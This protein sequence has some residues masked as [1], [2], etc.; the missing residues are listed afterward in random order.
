M[1]HMPYGVS[2]Q[3]GFKSISEITGQTPQT[4]SP[5]VAWLNLLH[6]AMDVRSL[7]LEFDFESGLGFGGDDLLVEQ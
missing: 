2:F 4:G 7:F 5:W 3:A 1:G 6:K